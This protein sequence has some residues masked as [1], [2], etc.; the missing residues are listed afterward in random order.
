V[1]DDSKGSRIPGFYKLPVGERRAALEGAAGVEFVQVDCGGLALDTAN[2]MIEN[3]VGTYALPLGVALNFRVNGEDYF[4]P[5][6]IEEPSVVAA[7]SHAAKLVRSAGGFAAEATAPVM[8]AQIQICDVEDPNRAVARIEAAGDEL[9]GQAATLCQGLVK[10]GGG[11]RG[12]EVRILSR[13]GERDGGMV[14]VHLLID[15]RDAMGANAVNTVAEGMADRLAALADGRPGLRILSNLCTERMVTVRA[16]ISDDALGGAEVAEVIAEASRFA[17]LDPYRATTHNKGIMNGIDAVL[18]ATGNDWR[19]VEA[20]AHAYA[21]RDGRYG[22]L[23]TWQHR[24]GELVGEMTLPLAAATVGGATQVHPGARLALA[25]LAASSAVELAQVVAAVGL[26]S[27]LAALRAL[28]TEGI[29]RGHMS[30]HARI[31]A[32]NAGAEGALVDR[33]A[34][35]IAALGD[36]RPERA[37]EILRRLRAEPSARTTLAKDVS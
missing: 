14:V 33:V 4:V 12:L 24:D 18:V 9:L 8:I 17:E 5:M 22:P 37:R 16:R 25:L 7:A 15:T 13:P 31:V 30:L 21:A 3:V 32:R 36:V 26:A 11:P 1:S 28:A 20:G 23:A 27:N 34:A 6:A 35:E 19:G 10:R 29:Q 2:T